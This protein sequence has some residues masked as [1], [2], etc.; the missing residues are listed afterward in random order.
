[1]LSNSSVIISACFKT[2]S[3]A[4]LLSLKLQ[5]RGWI[6]LAV[7]WGWSWIPFDFHHKHRNSDFVFC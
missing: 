7:F 3:V 5:V 4:R 1:V 6:Y 2:V